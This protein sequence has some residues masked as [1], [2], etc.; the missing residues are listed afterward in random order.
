MK[1]IIF[2]IML[3]LLLLLLNPNAAKASSIIIEDESTF[4]SEDLGNETAPNNTGSQP[5]VPVASEGDS[6][7][8]KQQ[9][10]PEKRETKQ[11]QKVEEKPE[12]KSLPIE[13]EA[14]ETI[15]KNSVVEE[16]TK[17]SVSEN[18]I[19]RQEP[20]KTAVDIEKPEEP[21]EKD[22]NAAEVRNE[23]A[24]TKTKAFSIQELKK[25]VAVILFVIAAVTMFYMIYG[26]VKIYN[27]SEDNKYHY[28]GQ[29]RLTKHRGVYQIH[30]SSM[31][32]NRGKTSEYKVMVSER[33]CHKNGSNSGYLILP[34]Q[35]RVEVRLR[36]EILFQYD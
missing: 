34:Q 14:I 12:E 35:E 36:N 30:V 33:I 13:E 4:T 11:T 21:I 16:Q 10:Q 23:K 31:V 8:E 20:D 25:G 6:V 28:I 5:A 15:S 24:E 2:T 3:L 27:L 17:E 18:T 9:K 1:K 7:I 29:C 26:Y 19:D 22:K 32:L